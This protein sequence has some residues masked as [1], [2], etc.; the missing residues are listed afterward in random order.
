MGDLPAGLRESDARDDAAQLPLLLARLSN[1]LTRA[2]RGRKSSTHTH[3]HTHRGNMQGSPA[4]SLTRSSGRQGELGGRDGNAEVAAC[5]CKS[6][7]VERDP[8]CVIKR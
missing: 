1:A 7:C 5:M 4:Q 3:T 8:K 2:V 6:E